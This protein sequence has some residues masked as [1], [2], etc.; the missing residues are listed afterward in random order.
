MRRFPA[1]FIL[2][3]LIVSLGGCEQDSRVPPTSEPGPSQ[4]QLPNPLPTGIATDQAGTPLTITNIYFWDAM[5]G[6]GVGTVVNDPFQHV[7][8]TT[9]QGNSWV[10]VTPAGAVADPQTP[11]TAAISAFVD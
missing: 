2:L 6:W 7:L 9:D 8:R 3:L 10:D 11:N 4:T 1:F 5:N